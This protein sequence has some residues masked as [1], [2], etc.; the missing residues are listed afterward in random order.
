MK[1]DQNMYLFLTDLLKK[2]NFKTIGLEGR[3]PLNRRPIEIH[4]N[5]LLF[6]ARFEPFPAIIRI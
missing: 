6:N 3:T 5:I 4:V 1:L 2:S